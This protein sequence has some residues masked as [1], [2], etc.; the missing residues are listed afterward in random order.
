MV[1][2][3]ARGASEGAVAAAV[4]AVL[5][6]HGR[7]GELVHIGHELTPGN[8]ELLREGLLTVA[9][10]QAFELQTRRAVELLLHR[11]GYLDAPPGPALVPFTLHTRENA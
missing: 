5:R 7:A 8:A 1:V 9:I 2:G 10:D 3:L 11:L 6:R 4:A